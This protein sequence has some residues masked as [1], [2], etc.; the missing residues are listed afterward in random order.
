MSVETLLSEV[1]PTLGLRSVIEAA[2][3]LFYR[4]QRVLSD[5]KPETSGNQ[6][7]QSNQG[8]QANKGGQNRSRQ[9]SNRSGGQ[10]RSRQNS[11]GN[12]GTDKVRQ[13][14]NDAKQTANQARG[15]RSRRASN[16]SESEMTSLRQEVQEL[17]EDNVSLRKEI[18]ELRQMILKNC[19]VSQT[20]GQK[21]AE[22][23]KAQAAPAKQEAATD[24]DFD[25]FGS[26]EED[27]EA[28]Q[29]LTEERLKAYAEKKNKKP[30]PIAK[31]N[32]IYD[33][34]P[35]DDTIDIDDIEKAVRSIEMDGLVW[36]ASKKVPVAFGLNK[37][38]ICCVVEDDKVSSDL[39]E[40]TIC[41][42]EDLVQSVDIVAFNKV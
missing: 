32:I 5:I 31:S 30:G 2:D 28:K 7:G 40:E 1:T 36:G 15:G 16:K 27:D 21:T 13:A 23:Q 19:N 9:N 33:V 37:L 25:L 10:N 38:Q 24:E 34:K 3:Q 41:N 6:G 4:D 42:N 26:D 12:K 35:W 11:Q 18:D 39:V 8:N 29:K 17:K 20:C 14:I 22:P